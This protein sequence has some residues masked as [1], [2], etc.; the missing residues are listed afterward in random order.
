MC[1][2]IKM[3]NTPWY[4]LSA[5][6]HSNIILSLKKKKQSAMY[7]S[8]LLGSVR[9]PF[10]GMKTRTR[11]NLM[12]FGQFRQLPNWVT[13]SCNAY[14]SISESLLL[15]LHFIMPPPPRETRQQQL[16]LAAANVIN[17]IGVAT[18]L[19]V[20]PLYWKQDYHTS[21][22]SGGEWVEEL[23]YSLKWRL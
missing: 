21:K 23:I 13:L 9:Y 15:C 14:Q 11:T 7:C 1:R 22:W 16:L 18:T 3:C 6:L 17:V 4:R 5:Q 2:Q 19:Y 12:A 20:S 10:L 8:V